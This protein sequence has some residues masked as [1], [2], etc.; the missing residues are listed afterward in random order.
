MRDCLFYSCSIPVLMSGNDV[1]GQSGAHRKL[2]AFNAVHAQRRLPYYEILGV[3]E[4]ATSSE[5]ISAYR[6]LSLKLHPDKPGGSNAKFQELS[7]AYKCLKEAESRRKYDDCGFDEDNIDTE[8][9]DTFVDAFFGESA[10]RIDGQSPDWSTGAITNYNRVD[11]AEVPLHMK[12]IVRVGLQYIVSLEHEFENVVLLQHSRIDILYLMVGI[13]AGGDLTQELFDSEDSYPITYYDN[14]L[15]PGIKPRWSD[16]NI[17]GSRKSKCK[18]LPRKELNAEEFLRRQK[19]ALAM[20]ENGPPDPMAALEEKYRNKMLAEQHKAASIADVKRHEA[21]RQQ[22]IYEEDAELDCNG[23]S[24]YLARDKAMNDDVSR[25]PEASKT[26]EGCSS[27]ADNNKVVIGTT[28]H[29]HESI[30]GSMVE[31]C[32]SQG[33]EDVLGMSSDGILF[34]AKDGK[35][36]RN[37]G[38]PMPKA[39]SSHG[40]DKDVASSDL[41]S[42]LMRAF[43]QYPILGCICC[44]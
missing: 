8:E 40:V 26:N 27:A 34:V 12:D 43:I 18:E 15:Q 39:K 16:Q 10:R 29:D 37:E 14:P 4:S 23:L 32:R 9:V 1:R 11:L 31:H 7:K 36:V 41:R 25:C 24:E 2:D 13:F 22:D 28:G 38:P 21:I 30:T 5:I 17:L 33:A 35:V 19:I 42:W 3:P 44:Q 6:K 20:L